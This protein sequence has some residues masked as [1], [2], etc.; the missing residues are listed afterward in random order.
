MLGG[1]CNRKIADYCEQVKPQVPEET[2]ADGCGSSDNPQPAPQSLRTLRYQGHQ[3]RHADEE[4]SH[5]C[6][7]KNCDQRSAR[8]PGD[9]FSADFSAKA[10]KQKDPEQ[11]I[12]VSVVSRRR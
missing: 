4:A 6:E 3:Q 2:Q 11:R 8:K 7:S 5:L 10:L 1:R 9:K 12:S